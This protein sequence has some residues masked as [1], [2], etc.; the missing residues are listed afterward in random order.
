MGSDVR[1]QGGPPALLEGVIR[2]LLPP[3]ARESVLGDLWERYR[4]PRQFLSE[5]VGTLSYVVAAQARR[6]TSAPIIGLQVFILFAC[7]GGFVPTLRPEA[8]PNSMRAG[9]PVA[10]ALLGLILRNVYREP[11]APVR[12]GLLDAATA[13]AMVLASQGLLALLLNAGVIG[14]G[15]MLSTGTYVL[16][17]LALPIL[18]IL[19]AVEGRDDSLRRAAAGAG[20]LEAVRLEYER[21]ANRTRGRNIAEMAA[22]ALIIGLSAYILVTTRPAAAPFGWSFLAGYAVILAYLARRGGAA[23]LPADADLA[24]TRALYRAELLRQDRLRQVMW[25]FWFVPLFAGLVTELLVFGITHDDP[26]R[27]LAGVATILLLGLCIAK[28]NADRGTT[29]RRKVASLEVTA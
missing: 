3:A 12:Q 27:I 8:V 4:S 26:A 5:G 14:P 11:G 2:V 21:F 18:C 13:A 19:G 16:G 25:W 20:S 23:A 29:V 17:A 24:A 28:I 9:I 15:W 1:Q 7:L 6:G 10:A 22:L